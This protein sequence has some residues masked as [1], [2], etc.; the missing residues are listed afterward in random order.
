MAAA[1]ANGG[2][3]G[4][5]SIANNIPN[6]IEGQHGNQD[7]FARRAVVVRPEVPAA[8]NGNDALVPPTRCVSPEPLAREPTE[9]ISCLS[10]PRSSTREADRQEVMSTHSNHTKRRR[11]DM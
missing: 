11:V 9:S 8:G 5:N 1:S 3:I 7:D 2:S 10:R 4:G 6:D